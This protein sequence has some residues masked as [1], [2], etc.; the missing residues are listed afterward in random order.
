MVKFAFP[1]DG[2]TIEDVFQD[3]TEFQLKLIALAPPEILK[4]INQG[5]SASDEFLYAYNF[6]VAHFKTN[7]IVGIQRNFEINFI[8]TFLNFYPVYLKDFELKFSERKDLLNE[9][10]F[11]FSGSN[12]SKTNDPFEVPNFSTSY[13]FQQFTGK[14]LREQVKT[15]IINLEGWVAEFKDLFHID[16]G[17]I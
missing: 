4:L 2:L 12:T 8:T 16:F 13:N 5:Q 15:K 14:E 11:N 10:K 7:F 17:E 6:L 9:G 1:I 3:V